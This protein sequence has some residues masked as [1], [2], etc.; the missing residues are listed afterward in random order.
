MLYQDAIVVGDM[1]KKLSDVQK[2]FRIDNLKFSEVEHCASRGQETGRSI[3]GAGLAS[4][5][6]MTGRVNDRVGYDV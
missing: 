1:V 3:T 4:L 6:Q 5:G 2:D